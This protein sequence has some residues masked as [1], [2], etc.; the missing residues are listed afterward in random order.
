MGAYNIVNRAAMQSGQ[1]EDISVVVA[2]LDAIAAVL[3]GGVD[4]TNIAPG[5]AIAYSKLLLTNG[6]VNSDVAAAAAIAYSKLLL[7]N[8]IK[9]ADLIGSGGALADMP[10]G[11]EISY[12][13]FQGEV[14][15]TATSEATATQI[16]AM[17]SAYTFDGA[18]PVWIEFFAP[19]F[20]TIPIADNDFTI[21]L[22]DGTSI[23]RLGF[24]NIHATSG[25]PHFGHPI[26]VKRKITPSAAAHTYS[27]RGSTFGQPWSIHAGGGGAG[28]YMPGF[29][30]VSRA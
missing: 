19:G 28:T 22:Y 7:T 24:S 29:I 6:I 20:D 18:T 14:S 4:N 17:P 23:G 15:V 1:A 5:A 3:N 12:N 11:R 9:N 13:E 8:S 25:T 16:V 27:I 30:R 2:N 26:Y 10:P 21:W